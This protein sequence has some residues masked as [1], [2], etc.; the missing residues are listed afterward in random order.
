MNLS[1]A[2]VSNGGKLLEKAMHES[3][4]SAGQMKHIKNKRDLF[5]YHAQ[6][7]GRHSIAVENLVCN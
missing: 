1:L 3:I 5:L 4:K 2:G 7:E 6:L